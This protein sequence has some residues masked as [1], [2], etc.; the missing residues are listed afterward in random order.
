MMR[1]KLEI[2]VASAGVGPCQFC[3]TLKDVKH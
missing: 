3:Q 1:E 2:D